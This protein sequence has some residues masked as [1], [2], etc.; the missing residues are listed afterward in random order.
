[1]GLAAALS[2]GRR[3]DLLRSTG[4]GEIVNTRGQNLA[5]FS[6]KGQNQSEQTQN[7]RHEPSFLGGFHAGCVR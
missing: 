1:M 4:Y 2:F 7:L 6:K 5:E 3:F